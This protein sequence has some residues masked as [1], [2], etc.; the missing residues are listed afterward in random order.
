MHD[1]FFLFQTESTLEDESRS[2]E[3]FPENRTMDRGRRPSEQEILGDVG[4]V[5]LDSKCCVVVSGP[6]D[7][8]VVSMIG[9]QARG[10]EII[11]LSYSV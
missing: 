7:L 1:R 9:A 11:P 2:V 3:G 8:T 10:W 5:I 4:D 6:E